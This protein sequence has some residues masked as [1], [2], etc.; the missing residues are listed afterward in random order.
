MVN[1]FYSNVREDDMI[2]PIFNN[3]IGDQWP[4]HLEKMYTFWQTVLLSEKTY[5]GRPFPPHATLP[6]QAEHFERWLTIFRST[7]TTLFAGE[8]ANEALWRAEKMATMFNF[9]VSQFQNKT[10]KPLI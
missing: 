10:Y 5:H 1:S 2:G 9:K 8:K 7:V 4:Q 3:V 6:I